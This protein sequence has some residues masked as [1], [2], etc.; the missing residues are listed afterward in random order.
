MVHFDGGA[1][2]LI[3]SLEQHDAAVLLLSGGDVKEGEQVSI[4]K[5][6]CDVKVSLGGILSGVG[7]PLSE[8][9]A[10]ELDLLLD[11]NT[12]GKSRSWMAKKGKVSTPLWSG[13]GD[14]A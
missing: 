9:D 8:G 7:E 6:K 3:C 13:I 1:V 10:G 14:R 2:G 4:N 11:P 12:S 5:S